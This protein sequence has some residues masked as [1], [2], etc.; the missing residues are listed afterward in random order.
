VNYVVGGLDNSDTAKATVLSV[1]VHCLS[2]SC[3]A[4]PRDIFARSCAALGLFGRLRIERN[5]EDGQLWGALL[6]VYLVSAAGKSIPVAF[7]LLHAFCSGDCRFSCSCPFLVFV[8]LRSSEGVRLRESSEKVE[9]EVKHFDSSLAKTLTSTRQQN[10]E[11]RM[12]HGGNETA[13]M[14]DLINQQMKTRRDQ[15]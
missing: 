13:G 15:Q 5:A 6:F 11:W 7:C 3:C 9:S 2:N 14:R 4:T 12:A 8:D 10:R 1:R